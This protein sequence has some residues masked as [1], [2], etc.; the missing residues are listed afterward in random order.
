MRQRREEE[1]K[2]Y[3][4]RSRKVAEKAVQF[5]FHAYPW[6]RRRSQILRPPQ[7]LLGAPGHIQS[8]IANVG[9]DVGS[10]IGRGHFYST[11]KFIS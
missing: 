11:R 8:L 10:E 9:N 2:Y 5:P 4:S 6:L 1:S 7:G 3:S